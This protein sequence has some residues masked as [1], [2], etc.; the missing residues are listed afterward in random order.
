MEER[1]RRPGA[2]GPTDPASAVVLDTVLASRQTVRERGQLPLDFAGLRALDA[3]ADLG[4]ALDRWLRNTGMRA[5]PG[6]GR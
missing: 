1:P 4:Q 5:R 3:L 6:C 2:P